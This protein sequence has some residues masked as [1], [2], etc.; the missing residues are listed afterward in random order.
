MTIDTF[1]DIG[2]TVNVVLVSGTTL[3]GYWDGAQW[4]AGIENCVDDLPVAN[5]YVSG[6]TA[7]E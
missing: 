4:W 6:W 1:P 2:V 7:Q 3:P 5:E